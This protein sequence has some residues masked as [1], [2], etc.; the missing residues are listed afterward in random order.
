MISDSLFLCQHRYQCI[1]TTDI[2]TMHK[3]SPRHSFKAIMVAKLIVILMLV[4]QMLH[5]EMICLA[6]YFYLKGFFFFSFVSSFENCTSTDQLQLSAMH[7]HH[8]TP[9]TYIKRLVQV[10][11]ANVGPGR[12]TDGLTSMPFALS[13]LSQNTQGLQKGT[14]MLSQVFCGC[15]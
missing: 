4:E 2:S 13:I 3:I 14:L 9:L 8:V 1:S 5:I 10:R 11:S 15:S 6:L 12:N 7:P